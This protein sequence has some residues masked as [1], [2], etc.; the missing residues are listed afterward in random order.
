MRQ[1]LKRR[2][3]QVLAE[4]ADLAAGDDIF[5]PGDRIGRDRNAGRQGFEQHHAIGVGAA[6][7]DE[8][9]TRGEGFGKRL[10]EQRAGKDRVRIGSFQ[11]SNCGPPPTMTFLPGRSR[12]RKAARFFST[13]TRPT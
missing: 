7:E 4:I 12:S 3:S 1:R 8:H 11:A 5:R 2:L 13:T 10:T 9:I 6:R